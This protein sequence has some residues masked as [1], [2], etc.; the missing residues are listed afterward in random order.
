MKPYVKPP[1]VP[2]VQYLLEAS[3]GG[4]DAAVLWD[5]IGNEGWGG[6]ALIRPAMLNGEP[7]KPDV[8][9][10]GYQGPLW[11]RFDCK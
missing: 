7:G 2:T 4:I 1:K 8:E 6:R 3:G 9:W 10:E 5:L 11:D